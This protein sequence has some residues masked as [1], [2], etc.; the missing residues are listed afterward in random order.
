MSFDNFD[1]VV[2]WAFLLLLI[3]GIR[4]ALENFNK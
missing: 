2:N 4:L 3:G 1:G